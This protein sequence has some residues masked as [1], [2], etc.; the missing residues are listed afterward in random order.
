MDVNTTLL[1]SLTGESTRWEDQERG[2]YDVDQ[3]RQEFRKRLYVT[4]NPP[5]E[6][7]S[8][9]EKNPTDAK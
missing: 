1:L 8:L 3:L 2:N 9:A 6:P 5:S 4:E 7:S